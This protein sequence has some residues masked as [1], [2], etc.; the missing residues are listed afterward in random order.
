MASTPAL[1]VENL[2]KRFGGAHALDR[3]TL[4]VRAG[5]VH[6]LLGENGSG[7]STLIKILAGFHAPEPGARL[8]VHG[9]E[10]KLPLSPGAFTELGLRFVHQDLGL[11]PSLTVVENLRLNELSTNWSWRLSWRSERR[12]AEAIFAS[13]GVNLDPTR[14][15]AD[16]SQVERALLAIVR[17][18]HGAEAAGGQTVLVLDEPTVFLPR[19]GAEQLFQLVRSIRE[20]GSS[21]LFVSHDLEEV[22][23]ITDRVTVLRDGRVQGT[24]NTADAEPVDL[25][26]LIVGR[27]FM[28]AGHIEHAARREPFVSVRLRARSGNP[29]EL[30]LRRGEVVGLTGLV[31]SGFEQLPY[32]LYGATPVD[33]GELTID[34]TCLD[35]AEM[36]P[37][38]ALANGLVLI[39]ANRQRDGSVSDLSI[40]ENVMLPVLGQ[41]TKS[42]RLRNRELAADARVL[43]DRF[44]VRPNRPDAPYGTLSGGNQQKAMLAKWLQLNPRILLLHEPT[45]GVD[46]GAREQIFGIVEQATHD[47]AAVICASSDYDQLARL[48]DRVLIFARGRVVQELHGGQ[49]SKDVITE[50]CLNSPSLLDELVHAGA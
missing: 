18:V 46:V 37:A 32:F 44:D 49:V 28:G 17:A 13:Q 31:G 5:E 41:F 35:L 15:V 36:T 7:K 6:G 48:C 2:S 40:A 23:E 24:V 45:Q 33:T 50:R 12:R 10:V 38:R 8:F 16:L 20:R 11:I 43:L 30:D 22:K 19:T 21:V 14:V 42:L 27:R 34:G 26:E 3:V 4:E 25:V 9:T 39:P 47:G 29:L 1:R